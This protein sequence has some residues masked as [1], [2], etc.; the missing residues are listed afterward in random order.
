MN[1]CKAAIFSI[2]GLWLFAAS[3]VQA[4]V[5]C[6]IGKWEVAEETFKVSDKMAS[7]YDIELSANGGL[8]I[9]FTPDSSAH[10]VYDNYVIRHEMVRPNVTILAEATVNGAAQGRYFRQAG[11]AL[12]SISSPDNVRVDTKQKAAASAWISMGEKERDPMHAGE[13]FTYSC[14]GDELILTI[15]EHGYFNAEYHGR[16]V[17]VD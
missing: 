13:D 5:M 14:S 8:T 7:R 12:L 3:T 16:F 6:L 9:E 11:T 2:S 4:D 1:F 10:L 17:R 15:F